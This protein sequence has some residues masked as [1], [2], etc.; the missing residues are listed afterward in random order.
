MARRE[1]SKHGFK[2]ATALFALVLGAG[3]P[4]AFSAGSDP[5]VDD[6]ADGARANA[7]VPSNWTEPTTTVTQVT[8]PPSQPPP[9][10]P[11]KA[12]SANP[13]WAMPLTQFPVT[14]ERPIFLPS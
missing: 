13:L 1:K 5:A 2:T 11:E 9:A 8:I 4:A 6:Q 12:L 3:A 14:R 10:A 7:A